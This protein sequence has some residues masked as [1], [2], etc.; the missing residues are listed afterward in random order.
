MTIAKNQRSSLLTDVKAGPGV[1]PIDYDGSM[2]L[3]KP[4]AMIY[5]D[6]GTIALKALAA[7]KDSVKTEGHNARTV[8]K[9]KGINIPGVNLESGIP[10][11]IGRI[12]R[13]EWKQELAT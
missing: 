12:S 1:I 4:G 11:R 7:A 2:R 13:S 5:I 9:H 3:I 10:T 8:K 6:D